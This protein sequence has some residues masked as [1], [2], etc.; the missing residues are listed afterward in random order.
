[1]FIMESCAKCSLFFT[2]RTHFLPGTHFLRPESPSPCVAAE[3]PASAKRGRQF[4]PGL[5]KVAAQAG[6]KY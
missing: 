1:M 4:L 2:F 5:R 3:K 6:N